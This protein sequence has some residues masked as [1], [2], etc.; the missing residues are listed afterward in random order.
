M[1]L[2]VLLG[3][4]A[5][6]DARFGPV[7]NFANID[8]RLVL[9]FALNIPQAQKSFWTN[10]KEHLGDMGHVESYFSP[11]RDIVSLGAR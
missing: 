1:H 5:Q 6:V 7:G 11:F 8:T 10:P 2:M 4:E 3:D 9:G